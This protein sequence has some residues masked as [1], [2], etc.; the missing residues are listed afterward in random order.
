MRFT[1]FILLL[2]SFGTASA[3][4]CGFVGDERQVVADS[5]E[6]AGMVFLARVTGREPTADERLPSERFFLD[7]GKV[8]KKSGPGDLGEVHTSPADPCG[9]QFEVG[10]EYVVFADVYAGRNFDLDLLRRR[11][12]VTGKCYLTTAV[13][14]GNGFSRRLIR[15]LEELRSPPEPKK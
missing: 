5:F 15:R 7:V 8:W 6:S 12:L 1:T 11:P 2:L 9:V 3:C 10:Q 4:D 13:T 14:S